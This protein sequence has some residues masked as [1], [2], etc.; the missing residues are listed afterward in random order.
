[1][2][3]FFLEEY[4]QQ[5]CKK[6]F[7]V[8]DT[9]PPPSEKAYIDEDNGKDWIAVVENH[10]KKSISFVPID[11]C[12][13]LRRPDNTMDNRCDGLLYYD[14]TIIFVELKNATSKGNDW[15]VHADKQLRATIGHFEISSH[16]KSIERK[17]AYIANSAKP[18]FRSS[19][20]ERMER[21]LSDTG[22]V[23]RI[24]NRIVV[25]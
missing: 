4:I 24:E 19:Q 3:E 16:D 12:I 5:S 20:A 23:L 11:N 2:S 10:D 8:C 13:E 1:M 17:R 9:P 6:R 25:D 15:I 14:T 7:G 22:Y 21:F 18:R